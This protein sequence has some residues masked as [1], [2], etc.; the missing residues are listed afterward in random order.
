MKSVL[1]V[2]TASIAA[3][4]I[5]AAPSAAQE[6]TGGSHFRNG[7]S[8]PPGLFVMHR[9]FPRAFG[10]AFGCDGRDSRHRDGRRHVAAVDCAAFG[11]GFGYFDQDINRSWDPDSFNDW[12][13]DRPDRAYPRWIYHN[14]NCTPD[15]MWWSGSGWH[16]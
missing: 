6:F 15:R 11:G 10:S 4:L 1:L 16:C 3:I 7:P 14:Q 5:P 9:S 2:A 12:W 8:A 13:N